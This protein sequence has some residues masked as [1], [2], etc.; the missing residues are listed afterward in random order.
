MFCD[1]PF[2][3]GHQMKH[4]KAQIYF[5]E[6]DDPIDPDCIDSQIQDQTM[7]TVPD[8]TPVISL[9]ALEQENLHPCGSGQLPQFFR[10][11]DRK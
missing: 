8:N 7:E 1:E 5:I 4:K 6:A 11:Q 3:P 2:T 10:Q 9:H